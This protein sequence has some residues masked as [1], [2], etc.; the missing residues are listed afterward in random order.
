M[1]LLSRRTAPRLSYGHLPRVSGPPSTSCTGMLPRHRIERR[2]EAEVGHAGVPAHVGH[3]WT[4]SRLSLRLL[5]EPPLLHGERN[6]TFKSS[7]CSMLYH[8][9]CGKATDGTRTRVAHRWSASSSH[10]HRGVTGWPTRFSASSLR[11]QHTDI[12]TNC[13]HHEPRARGTRQTK[14]HISTK[15]RGRALQPLQCCT[16]TSWWVGDRP[17]APS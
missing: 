5:P 12:D 15:S 16:S 4:T 1:H 17:R 6:S 2:I 13:T 8:V 7:K 3:G 10:R 14:C 9:I 11:T